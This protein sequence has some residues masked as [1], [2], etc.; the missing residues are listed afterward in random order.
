MRDKLIDFL[1]EQEYG[2]NDGVSNSRPLP[3]EVF[4]N[5]DKLEAFI[6]QL[7]DER[8]IVFTEDELRIIQLMLNQQN[9]AI[10][11]PLTPNGIE[12]MNNLAMKLGE[13]LSNLS[14]QG[15]GR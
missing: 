13:V 3:L 2:V 5:T 8:G 15:N 14:K 1:Y 7:L 9:E 10:T 6:Q 11:I 12:V 4:V